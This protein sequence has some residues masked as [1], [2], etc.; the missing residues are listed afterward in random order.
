MNQTATVRL[1]A[2]QA[3][4]LSGLI[5]AESSFAEVV[6]SHPNIRLGHD[7]IAV[8]RTNAE[9][10]SDYFTDRL[11]KVGFDASYEPNDEGVLL[12]SLVDA[13][14]VLIAQKK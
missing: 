13:L 1:T 2:E 7:G 8:D 10:L 11:A 6:R 5:A 9:M 14:F 4:Y 12:E 3:G